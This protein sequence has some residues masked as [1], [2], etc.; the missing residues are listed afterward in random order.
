HEPVGYAYQ[1][2]LGEVNGTPLIH[3]GLVQFSRR[4]APGMIAA[5]TVPL[6]WGNLKNHGRYACSNITHIPLIASVFWSGVDDVYPSISLP[7]EQ[8]RGRYAAQL[9]RLTEQYIVPVLGYPAQSVCRETYRI[10]GS[11]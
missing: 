11:L 2:D 10:C 4:L 1:F 9:E 7:S 6:V 5:A 3:A 8:L